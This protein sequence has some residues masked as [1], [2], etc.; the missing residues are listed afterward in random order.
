MRKYSAKSC[1]SNG[2]AP[3]L[4]DLHY[5]RASAARYGTCC[6]MPGSGDARRLANADRRRIG[7]WRRSST[8]MVAPCALSASLKNAK[9]SAHQS[10]ERPVGHH[11][12]DY[13][14]R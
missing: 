2:W 3:T 4:G 11:S 12:L 14:T 9:W 1:G 5:E 8:A 7:C 10:S 13:G 6:E